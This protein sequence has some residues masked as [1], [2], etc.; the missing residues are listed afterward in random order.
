MKWFNIAD[1]IAARLTTI[2]TENGF[3]TDI[4][5]NVIRGKGAIPDGN[6]GCAVYLNDRTSA[7]K[8]GDRQRVTAE[9]VIE[10][11][12]EYTGTPELMF[13]N[14]LTDIQN[15]IEIEDQTLSVLLYGVGLEWVSDNLNY[16]E[17]N[18]S[19]VGVQVVYNIPHIRHFGEP[20]K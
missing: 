15:A 16:P 14:L 6:D 8:N 9:I 10:A 1:I 11:V 13:T 7:E 2:T 18:S 4:G 20:T 19:K 5:E 12:T 17:N 3:I